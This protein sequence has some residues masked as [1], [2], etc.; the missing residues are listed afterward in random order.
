MYPTLNLLTDFSG[1][2]TGLCCTVI[3]LSLIGAILLRVGSMHFCLEP[4]FVSFLK[5]LVLAALMAC[6]EQSV[7]MS[8]FRI[9]YNV[10]TMVT[11]KICI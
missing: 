8:R 1:G 5:L 10:A 7:Q 6:V 11:T 3:T 2:R 4:C 9:I